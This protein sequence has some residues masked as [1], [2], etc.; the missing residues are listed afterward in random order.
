MSRATAQSLDITSQLKAEWQRSGIN[1]RVMLV[2][3]SGL[4]KSTFTRA[5]LRPY[6]PEEQLVEGEQLAQEA[7]DPIRGRTDEIT[8]TIHQIENDGYPVEFTIVDCPGYGDALDSSTWINSMIDYLFTKFGAHYEA[9]CAPASDGEAPAL[10]PHSDGLVHVCLYFIAA[11]RLKGVDV[12]FMKRLE[13]CVNLIPVIAKADTM[14]VNERDAFRREIFS[15]LRKSRVRIFE[16]E[17]GGQSEERVGAGLGSTMPPPY[18]VCASEAGFREYPWGRLDI[19][20][21]VHSDLSLLRR[22]LFTSSML[23]AKRRSLALYEAAYAGGRRQAERLSQ[24]RQM[25]AL[26]HERMLG[27]LM[28]LAVGA[29]GLG[30]LGS[31]LRPELSATASRRLQRAARTIGRSARDVFGRVPWKQMALAGMEATGRLINRGWDRAL[32]AAA[33]E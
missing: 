10:S 23:A 12:E 31:R 22:A 21:P 5:L 6:V 4:G 17:G 25:R 2:G 3:E 11:H 20:D 14:T 19:E 30:V 18:A 8:E 24:K 16:L 13:R 33:K 9:S 27:R 15:Q 26:R 1:F 32:K 29:G 28:M 7:R